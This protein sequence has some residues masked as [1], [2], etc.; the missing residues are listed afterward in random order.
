MTTITRS[1]EVLPHQR[2]NNSSPLMGIVIPG[3]T[4]LYPPLPQQPDEMIYTSGNSDAGFMFTHEGKLT[5]MHKFGN[6]YGILGLNVENAPTINNIIVGTAIEDLLEDGRDFGYA[7]QKVISRLRGPFSAIAKDDDNLYLGLDRYGGSG[8]FIGELSV[9]GY[10]AS[11]QTEAL[12][13]LNAKPVL[14]LEP[15]TIARI[16]AET[17]HCTRWAFPVHQ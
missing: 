14:E 8:M 17:I 15:G 12:Q 16:G 10:V 6:R 13:E 1:P 7:F 3:D 11:A 9:G 5:E 4:I 2:N